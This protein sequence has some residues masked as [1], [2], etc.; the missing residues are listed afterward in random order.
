MAS[1]LAAAVAALLALAA[2]TDPLVLALVVVGVQVLLATGI[3]S[4]GLASP[5]GTWLVVVGSGLTASVLVAADEAPTDLGA[6]APAAAVAVVAAL[7][8]ELLRRDGR[9]R[10]TQSVALT[11]SGALLAVLVAAWPVTERLTDGT[12]AVVLGSGGIAVACLAWVLPGPRALLGPVAVALAAAGGSVGAGVIGYEPGPA[13]AA[14]VAG[15]GGLVA[16][17]SLLATDW[18]TPRSREHVAL[19]ATLPLA[20][21]APL[22]HVVGRFA[23]ALS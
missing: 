23:A 11:T 13:G 9:R 20:L 6:L 14:A 17:L 1:L 3:A 21:A 12:D 2:R 4:T 22:V 19:V 7:L 8:R 10:V 15:A 18:W 5:R 16:M